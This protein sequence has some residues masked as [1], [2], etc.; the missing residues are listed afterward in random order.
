MSTTELLMVICPV[1][2]VVF[3]MTELP[4]GELKTT[5]IILAPV[6]SSPLPLTDP[7]IANL[8]V[9]SSPEYTLRFCPNLVN[10]YLLLK[11]ALQCLDYVKFAFQTPN[12][13]NLPTHNYYIRPVS[14]VRPE[15][16]CRCPGSN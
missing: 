12:R 5:K 9:Q 11:F 2:A 4:V 3:R 16:Y 14:Q 8:P 7:V 6:T 13:V 15:R 10:V 1:E